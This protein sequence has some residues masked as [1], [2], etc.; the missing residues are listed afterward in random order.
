MSLVG[1]FALA[2]LVLVG[3]TIPARA[4][5]LGPD[6]LR[7]VGFDQRLGE[8]I[9]LDLVFRDESGQPIELGS[10]V[11]TRPIILTL[12]YFDCANLCPLT[13]ESLAGGLSDLPFTLGEQFSVLSVS[14]DPRESPELAAAKKP[15][16]LRPYARPGVERGWHFLTGE[17]G[18]IER[19]TRAVGFRYA[20]DAD[21]DQYAHPAGI[22]VLTPGGRVARYLYG[23]DY[24]PTDLR[25]AL[26]EAAEQWI[27]SA[28]DQA[29]LLCYHYDPATGR[30]TPA[31]LGAVRLAG[32]ATVLGVGALLGLLWRTDL[33]RSGRR[34]R[35]VG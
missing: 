27:G 8:P 9:P 17:Q 19:L 24:S 1:A 12:N 21:Q 7:E 26:V 3:L 4:H 2:L 16:Y 25:L 23:L 35:P 18:A 15:I 32:A 14:I 29:L 30:Y 6:E 34:G 28:I 5:G 31:V 13:I 33:R 11:H 22:V 20:Y 10:Y